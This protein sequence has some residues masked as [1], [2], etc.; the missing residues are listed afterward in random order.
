MMSRN[1]YSHNRRRIDVETTLWI[2]WHKTT[3][4]SRVTTLHATSDVNIELTSNSRRN[5]KRRRDD[6]DR[7]DVSGSRQKESSKLYTTLKKNVYRLF[8]WR[9]PDVGRRRI[10]YRIGL[11][12]KQLFRV[13]D[14]QS[15]DFFQYASYSSTRGHRFKLY[16]NNTSVRVR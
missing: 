4:G 16:K 5:W 1:I 11:L 14:L 13:V 7:S 10:I 15:N 8:T 2:G 12:R 3:S 6:V 9:H